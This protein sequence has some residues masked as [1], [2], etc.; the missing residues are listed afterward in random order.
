MQVSALVVDVMTEDATW[1]TP[2]GYKKR[3][4]VMFGLYMGGQLPISVGKYMLVPRITQSAGAGPIKTGN[5]KGGFAVLTDTRVGLD[6]R[7][8]FSSCDLVLGV[9]YDM[10]WLWS[11]DKMNLTLYKKS[12]LNQ[13]CQHGVGMTFSVAW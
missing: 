8:P 11:A 4:G 12:A 7:I 1:G 5:V 3:V 2:E 9:H 10:N 6:W 13:Y